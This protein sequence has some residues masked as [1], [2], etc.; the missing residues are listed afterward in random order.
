MRWRLSEV[1]LARMAVKFE[2]AH[3]LLATAP[4]ICTAEAL[5]IFVCRAASIAFEVVV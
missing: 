1:L 4:P 5:G 3:R 2:A